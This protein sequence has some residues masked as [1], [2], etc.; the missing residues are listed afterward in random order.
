MS[1]LAR[2]V[3]LGLPHHVTRRGNHRA[4]IFFVADDDALCRDLL[5]ARAR[6]AGVEIWAG[7]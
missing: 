4:P 2:I 6:K 3:A 1:R 5:A 7:A